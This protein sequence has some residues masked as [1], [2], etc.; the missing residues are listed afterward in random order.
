MSWFV[1][2]QELSHNSHPL[3]SSP[4]RFFLTYFLLFDDARFLVGDFFNKWVVVFLIR[5]DPI[6][7]RRKSVQP[8][9]RTI[10]FVNRR[11][12]FRRCVLNDDD[13]FV[14]GGEEVLTVTSKTLTKQKK[15]E[16]YEKEKPTE[17]DETLV[18][19]FFINGDFIYLFIY[20]L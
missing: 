14:L 7:C 17:T 20:L 9:R 19:F 15:K 13:D 1:N 8:V 10:S 11:G 16:T 5:S 6:R 12:F 2:E 18:S 4:L 3:I